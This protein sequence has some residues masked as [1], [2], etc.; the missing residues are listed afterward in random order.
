MRIGSGK[1]VGVL[2]CVSDARNICSKLC[3]AMDA[4]GVEPFLPIISH[5]SCHISEPPRPRV[6]RAAGANVVAGSWDWALIVAVCAPD[7][8]RRRVMK[9]TPR[10]EAPMLSERVRLNDINGWWLV[11]D[12]WLVAATGTGRCVF[13]TMSERLRPCE[14]IRTSVRDVLAV[15]ETMEEALRIR[16]TMALM[17]LGAPVAA[18]LGGPGAITGTLE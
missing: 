12:S 17:I 15:P 10:P 3:S 13:V 9:P 2:A 6:G 7:A 11:S 8:L 1:L 18:L 4:S 16:V 14:A 5:L